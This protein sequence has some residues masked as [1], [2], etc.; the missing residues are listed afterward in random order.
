MKIIS[1]FFFYLLVWFIGILPYR[2][3]YAFSWLIYVFL[4]HVFSYRKKVVLDNFHLVFPKK[5]KKELAQLLKPVYMNL[6]DII[7]E[8]FRSFTMSRKQILRRHKILNPEIV[9]P[10]YEAGKSIIAVTGHYG[11]W[12]W[13]SLSANLQIDYKTFA[14][15]KP[16]SNP[17]L[18]KFLLKSRARFGTTLAPITETTKTFEEN[19]QIPAIYM[20]AA[21]QSPSNVSRAYWINFLGIDTA[22]LH[23]PEKHARNN[24]YPIMYVDIQRVKRGFY[25]IELSL[26]ADN[27]QDLQE[28]E[29]TR[30]YAAKLESVILNKP[31]NWLWSHKRWK[32]RR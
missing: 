16:L 13:G 30:R 4:F 1:A 29:I 9:K 6:S 32:L 10:Y 8:G 22:F 25:E 15:Y 3:M 2:L 5:D 20:L 27:P 11:N 26:L 17:Y 23:G 31:Q 24:N 7:V 28:G 19:R 18:N 14:I 12:E 21:D